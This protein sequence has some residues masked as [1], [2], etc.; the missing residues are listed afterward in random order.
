VPFKVS[1]V[2]SAERLA[3]APQFGDTIYNSS[4]GFVEFY[5]EDQWISLHQGTF[6]G[7]VET[8]TGESN[9]NNVVVAG[10]LTVSGTTTTVDTENTTISDNVIVLN[11]GETGAGVTATT[12]GI[13]IDRGT[14]SNKTFVWDDSVDK[15]T[16]GSETL[17]AG[18]FES[19]GV[20]A[21]IIDSSESVNILQIKAGA[22]DDTNSTIFINPYGSDTYINMQAETISFAT[23]PY[24]TYDSPYVQFKTE[25]AFKAY[26]GAYFD[27][28]LIGD[29]KGSV[30]GDD[31]TILVD[32][33]GQNCR[34]CRKH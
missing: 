10:D 14:E 29:V 20:A 26:Q 22:V 5:Q 30:V 17:V 33:V 18:R 3:I 11:N 12:A 31:S 2:S 24:N 28:N 6:N 23:G 8:A 13:E 7:N 21:S 16:L 25:G 27:G 15:W 1:S 19:V 34:R 9:F 32:G 4:T